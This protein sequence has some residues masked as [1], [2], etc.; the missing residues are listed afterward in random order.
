MPFSHHSHSGQFCTHAT[1]TLEEMVQQAITSNMSTFALTEHIPRDDIDL[2]PSESNHPHYTSPGG[3]WSLFS[4][5]HAEALRLRE[6]YSGQINILIGFEIEWIRP[7]SLGIIEKVMREHRFDLFVGSLHHVHT[8]PIDYDDETFHQ[9]KEK[10]GGSVEKLFEYYFDSQAEMLRVLEPPVV[11]HFDLIRLKAE[12]GEMLEEGSW[13][14][15]D[16]RGVWERIERNLRLVKGYGGVLE[17]NTSALRKGL[18]EP[19]PRREICEVSP[20]PCSS[21]FFPSMLRL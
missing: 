15:R 7:S 9:A 18:G 13:S 1:N 17:V 16:W 19:Y 5:Y 3:L 10:S 4:A 21:P 14:W 8:I 12:S 20:V 2:Y 6:K 11:G